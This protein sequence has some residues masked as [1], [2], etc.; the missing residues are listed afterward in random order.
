MFIVE[1]KWNTQEGWEFVSEYPTIQKAR[2]CVIWATD[3]PYFVM[4]R[5]LENGNCIFVSRVSEFYS[6]DDESVKWFV[7][8]GVRL[9][10]VERNADNPSG[11]ILLQC[12]NVGEFIVSDFDEARQIVDKK[13]EIL[14]RST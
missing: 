4:A 6:I 2:K 11:K 10:R 9:S 14:C 5:I 1:A 8:Y 3:S 13:Y 12:P 7:E